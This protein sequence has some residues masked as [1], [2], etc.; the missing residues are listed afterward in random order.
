[1]HWSIS[2]KESINFSDDG[3][4]TIMKRS[5]GDMRKVLNIMQAV[6]TVKNNNITS[7]DVGIKIVSGGDDKTFS[8]VIENNTVKSNSANG[9][10]IVADDT[11][12]VDG[13]GL[14][15][16]NNFTN[17]NISNNN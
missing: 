7:D 14:V 9:I 3:I 13:Y 10:S 11:P 12:G 6:S 16:D 2:E 4:N 5:N 1:M 8:N 15:A 17:N